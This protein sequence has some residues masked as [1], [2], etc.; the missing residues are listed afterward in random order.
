MIFIEKQKHKLK[1][2]NISNSVTHRINEKVA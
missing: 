1:T 2:N